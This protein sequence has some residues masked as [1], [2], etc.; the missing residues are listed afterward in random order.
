M[1]LL[2]CVGKLFTS[3]VNAHLTLYL[4]SISGIGD[5][6]VGFREGHSTMDHV[7]M[8]HSVIDIYLHL[9]CFYWL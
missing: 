8:L 9:L 2:S 7:F 6:Q 3:A 4:N 5:E 1:T